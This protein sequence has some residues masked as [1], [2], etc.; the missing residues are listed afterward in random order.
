LFKAAVIAVLA[1]L[2]SYRVADAITVSGNRIADL[3]VLSLTGI[4]WAGAV[5]AGLWLLRSKLPGDLRRRKAIAY[6]RA[7]EAQVEG[8]LKGIEP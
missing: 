3:K 8:I 6:P 4:T 7:G 5:A 2:L 1:G